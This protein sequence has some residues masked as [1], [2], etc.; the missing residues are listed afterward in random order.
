MECIDRFYGEEQA[1][2]PAHSAGIMSI[3]KLRDAI[4]NA[5]PGLARAGVNRLL[6]RGAGLSVEEILLMESKK[7]NIVVDIF[8]NN[9]KHMLLIKSRH[10]S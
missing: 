6:A 10:S 1:C 4:M 5:D 7:E 8:K 9:L 3:E 2:R